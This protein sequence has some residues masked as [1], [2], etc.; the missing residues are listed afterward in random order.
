MN[1]RTGDL[2]RKDLEEICDIWDILSLKLP[3]PMIKIE[4]LC[5][6]KYTHTHIRIAK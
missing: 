6:I 1:N 3:G 5:L 2:N 4:K